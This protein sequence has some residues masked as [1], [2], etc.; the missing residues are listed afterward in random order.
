MGLQRRAIDRRG[1]SPGRAV[2][3]FRQRAVPLTGQ[4]KSDSTASPDIAHSDGDQ[5]YEGG[6][7]RDRLG[8]DSTSEAPFQLS[9]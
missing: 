6:F 8:C 9:E 2:G 3:L 5:G 7:G 1:R 4:A